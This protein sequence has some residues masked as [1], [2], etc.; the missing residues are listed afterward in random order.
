[1]AE[2]PSPG[3]LP[4]SGADTASQIPEAEETPAATPEGGLKGMQALQ[5]GLQSGEVNR[6][7]D[8]MEANAGPPEEGPLAIPKPTSSTDVEARSDCAYRDVL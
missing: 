5:R 3:E 6:I 7:V 1:M 4:L 2:Q 8:D